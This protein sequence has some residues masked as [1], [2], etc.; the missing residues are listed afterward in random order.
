MRTWS[1]AQTH[2]CTHAC[3][4]ARTHA[5][6]HARMQACRHACK[7]ART[8]ASMHAIM[9]LLMQQ[10]ITGLA[11]ARL[12]SSVLHSTLST[13]AAT[14][15]RRQYSL[16][17]ITWAVLTDTLANRRTNNNKVKYRIESCCKKQEPIPIEVYLREIKSRGH[18]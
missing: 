11:S 13:L 17:F 2:A 3:K 7:H 5:S 14:L 15:L 12:L 16:I 8:H 1:H 9:L 6:M 4:H 18:V 10:I